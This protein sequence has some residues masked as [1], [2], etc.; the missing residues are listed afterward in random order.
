[1][2]TS[3]I[4]RHKTAIRRGDFSRPVKCLLRDG[5]IGKES[6]FFDYGCGRG[7]DIQLLAKEGVTC[8]GWDP[9]FRPKSPVVEADLVNLGYVI[10]VIEDLNERAHTLR[11]AW[12]LCRQLMIVSAQVK[13]TGWGKS[14]VEFGD[15]VLTSR[16]TFQKLFDQAELRA[17]VES[18]LETE[19]IPAEIGIFYLF[20]DGTRRQQFLA[21]CFRRREVAPRRRVSELR[22][23]D[24]REL[25]DPFMALA[26]S[27][28]RI[29]DPAELPQAEAITER[30]GSLKRAFA[31]V[32]RI[33]GAEEWGLIVQRR[34]EDILVY[35]A[36]SRFGKRPLFSELPPTLQR[37]MR[38]FFGTYG[39]ACAQADDLLFR[40]GDPEAVD[41]ACKR[42]VIG[43]VLPDDLYVHRSALD[44]LEPILR[45]YEG[46]GRA[47]LGE[48]EGAN[49]I[50]I[51]RRSGKI[52]Y[53]VYPDFEKNPHPPLLRCMRLS[54]RM[55]QLDCYDYAESA[56]PPI[57]HRKETFLC[58]DHPLYDKF[59]RLT[60]QEEKHGLLADPVGIGTRASWELRLSNAGFTIR[61]H[62]LVRK[63]P[64]SSIGKADS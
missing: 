37:D 17:Y 39:K 5:L 13:V 34:R 52:S 33:S 24:N 23:E 19:A 32:Q 27:L 4:E 14:T 62:K 3:R 54:L 57:L 35:L 8:G 41:E 18:V 30:F 49:I 11:R 36:L 46:C 38:A 44:S 40:A 60:R 28:G 21:N 12:A 26:A 61:G 29:P 22:Y 59:A 20:K 10:N 7:E 56:N 45:V 31:F 9:A 16:G 64:A 15:G 2:T 42:S 6:T 25:L 63:A 51:H 47:Y 43:K 48:A 53:L 50:K 58:P 1:M 55:R